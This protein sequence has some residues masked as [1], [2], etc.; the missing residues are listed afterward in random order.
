MKQSYKQSFAFSVMIFVVGM[1]FMTY[2]HSLALG[3][4]CS[5]FDLT[6][7]VT[8]PGGAGECSDV[9]TDMF[10]SSSIWLVLWAVLCFFIF[11]IFIEHFLPKFKTKQNQQ[12]K[13]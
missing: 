13:K 8:Q 7:Q 1:A 9:F 5:D 12:K 3:E 11:L 4:V 2:S 10:F 6:A